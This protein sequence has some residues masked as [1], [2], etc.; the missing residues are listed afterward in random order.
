MTMQEQSF[1]LVP[2]DWLNEISEKL[3]TI[4]E[5]G[6]ADPEPGPTM[7]A[8]EAAVYLQ[9]DRNTLYRWTR[10]NKIPHLKVGRKIYYYKGELDSWMRGSE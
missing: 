6:R 4:I 2:R 9:V 7:T 5:R 10:Q 3:D 1:V 8:A